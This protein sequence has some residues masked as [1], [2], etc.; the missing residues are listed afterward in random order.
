MNAWFISSRIELYPFAANVDGVERVNAVSH[1][2]VIGKRDA[3]EAEACRD[4]LRAQQ[5]GKEVRLGMADARLVLKGRR[6]PLL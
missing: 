4:A 2:V 1:G 3:L 6:R 5:R